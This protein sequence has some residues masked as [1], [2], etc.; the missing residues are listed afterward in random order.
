MRQLVSPCASC[1]NVFFNIKH[2]Y[3]IFLGKLGKTTQSCFFRV[4]IKFF[5]DMHFIEEK[6]NIKF[7][8]L[9]R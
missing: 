7:N 8:K 5:N 4:Y 1:W 3:W 9:N 6:I 2:N